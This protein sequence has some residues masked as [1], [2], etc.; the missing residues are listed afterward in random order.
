M[1]AEF[2]DR[3]VGLAKGAH[4]AEFLKDK[5]LPNVVYVRNGES[6]EAVDVPARDRH[7]VLGGFDDMV[8][9]LLDESMAPDPEVFVDSKGGIVALLDRAER[10]QTASI[11][12]KLATRMETVV[13]LQAGRAFTPKQAV[14]FLQ[15]DLYAA[16]VKHVVQALRRIDFKRTSGGHS[17]VQHGRESL[18]RQVEL[19]VQQAED[20][21][22]TFEVVV[23][24][25]SNAGFSAWSVT[26]TVSLHLN[27]EEERVELRVLPDEVER[28]I[29]GALTSV[30]QSIEDATAERKVRVFLGRA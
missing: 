11:E 12:L 4:R 13:A 26:I 14:R 20:V 23:P 27:I 5:D 9:V 16:N 24:V 29:N 3:I 7:H 21:P 8:R 28:A 15:H 18:G 19:E 6:L 30:R 10:R 25:W 2:L 17:H 22:E 1:L